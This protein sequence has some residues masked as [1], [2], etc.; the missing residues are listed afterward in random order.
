MV[1]SKRFFLRGTHV[2]KMKKIIYIN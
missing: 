2:M 1:K